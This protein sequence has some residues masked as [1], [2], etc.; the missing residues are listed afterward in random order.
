V[1]TSWFLEAV[2]P[3]RARACMELGGGLLTFARLRYWLTGF[4]AQC[5]S[6]SQSG[7]TH[8]HTQFDLTVHGTLTRIV[9][10]QISQSSA[11]WKKQYVS[12]FMSSSKPSRCASRKQPQIADMRKQSSELQKLD[13]RKMRDQSKFTHIPL[14]SFRFFE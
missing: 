13:I 5:F 6:F 8:L 2:E 11:L 1:V 9:Y 12:F 14:S 7:Q 3:G 4:V 10:E